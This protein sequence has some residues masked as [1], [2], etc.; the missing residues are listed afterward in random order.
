VV[1]GTVGAVGRAELKDDDD[2][3]DDDVD[4]VMTSS[5]GTPD[6][7]IGFDVDDDIGT[8]DA[9]VLILLPPPFGG[10]DAVADVEMLALEATDR[11]ADPFMAS[12]FFQKIRRKR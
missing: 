9:L 10:N 8:P 12:F 1:S 5:I 7:V 2:S 6:D 3:V 11:I 4:D